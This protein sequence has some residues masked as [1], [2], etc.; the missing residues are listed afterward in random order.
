MKKLV[1]NEHNS[2]HTYEIYDEL[3]NKAYWKEWEIQ[4]IRAEKRGELYDDYS[5]T[6]RD[7]ESYEK[8]R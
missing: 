1:K 8:R 2:E 4:M 7:A 6:V 3:G 5:D